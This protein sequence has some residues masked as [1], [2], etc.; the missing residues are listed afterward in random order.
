VGA[1]AALAPRLEPAEAARL[2]AAADRLALPQADGQVYLVGAKPAFLVKLS[3]EETDYR[4]RLLAAAVA[5]ASTP[6][7]PLAVLHPLRDA[8]RPLPGRFREQQL[9]DFLK[10][11]TCPRAAQEA[12]LGKLGEQCGRPFANRWE[13]VEWARTHRPDLDLISP[14]ARPPQS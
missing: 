10:M 14:P 8:C 2:A 5:I 7:C 9:V 11:P 12:I 13:F 1:V 4:S 6:P 3:P